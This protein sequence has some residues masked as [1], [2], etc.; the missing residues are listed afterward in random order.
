[1]LQIAQQFASLI[2]QAKFDDAKQLLAEDCTYHYFEGSYAGRENIANIYRM[3][4]KFGEQH[5][6]EV[7]L[8]SVASDM[9]DGKHRIQ[10]N[11]L[12]R[13]GD[14]WHSSHSEEI[15]RIEDGLIRH[16]EH[17]TLPEEGRAMAEFLREARS[18]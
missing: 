11:D 15:L 12:L 9:A 16:I 3:H 17:I 4:H 8:S 18:H 7:R 1:M 13:L 6:D 14:R 2:D 10:F 5:F